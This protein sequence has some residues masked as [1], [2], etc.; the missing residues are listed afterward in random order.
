MRALGLVFVL[1]LLNAC[2]GGGG[3]IFKADTQY[4]GYLWHLFFTQNDLTTAYAVDQNAHVNIQDAWNITK[5]NGVKVAIIDDSFVPDHEDIADNVIL[6]YDAS[7]PDGGTDVTGTDTSHGNT[8]AGHL[9]ALDNSVGIIG[10]APEAELI[11]IKYGFSDAA[12]IRAFD[13]ALSEGAKVICCSWGSYD[14]S[15]ALADKVREAYS[16]G[17]TVIFAVGNDARSLDDAGVNDE[18]ELPYALGVGASCENNDVCSYSNYG[19]NV[20]VIAPGGEHYDSIGL[21]GLDNTG[22]SGSANQK[23]LVNNNYAFSSGTSFSTPIVA[24]VVALMYSIKPDIT[25][26]QVRDIL[27]QSA[28]KVG[29]GVSYDNDG[30]NLERAYGK[31]DAYEAIKLVQGL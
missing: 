14:V 6:T 4:D 27:I 3:G 16:A 20:D 5:G 29:V 10:S 11:L 2:S 30:F 12:D 19:A 9:A 8:V 24:G 31:V 21:L 15:Q 22:E 26:V 25:P 13:K 1:L 23:G 7:S 28:Q 18:S 17:V